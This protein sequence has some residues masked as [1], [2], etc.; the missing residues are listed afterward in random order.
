YPLAIKRSKLRGIYQIRSYI[1]SL[2]AENM[3][4]REFDE[5]EVMRLYKNFCDNDISGYD[6]ST[7]NIFSLVYAN[8]LIADYLKKDPG[9]LTLTSDDCAAAEKLLSEFE[10]NEQREIFRNVAQRM[11]LPEPAYCMKTLDVLMPGMLNA[12]KYNKLANFLVVE[13]R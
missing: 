9:T 1:D 6:E 12:V 13:R 8:A 11:C 3:I 2:T 10:D 7:V 4:C 5:I